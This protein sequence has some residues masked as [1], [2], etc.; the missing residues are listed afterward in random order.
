[1]STTAGKG[2]MHRPMDAKRFAVGFALAVKKPGGTCKK[3]GQRRTK[4]KNHFCLAEGWY[5]LRNG[6]WRQGPVGEIRNSDSHDFIAKQ[7]GCA[8]HQAG[9]FN[10]KYGHTGA[11][12][13][14]KGEPVFKD[15]K[16]LTDFRKAFGYPVW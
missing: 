14:S 5:Q 8:Q 12:W 11:K 2:D 15:A 10:K 7:H 6:T 13:N 16:S 9:A 1:M 4:G 3:C